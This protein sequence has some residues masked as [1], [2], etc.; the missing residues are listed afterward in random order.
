MTVWTLGRSGL[1]GLA[2]L[3]RCAKRLIPAGLSTPRSAARSRGLRKSLAAGGKHQSR[4]CRATG[5]A[6]GLLLGTRSSRKEGQARRGK[7]LLQKQPLSEILFSPHL[8]ACH[9]LP[10]IKRAKNDDAQ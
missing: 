4:V 10:A 1:L 6:W 9:L 7:P 5:L 3:G 8:S 2:P